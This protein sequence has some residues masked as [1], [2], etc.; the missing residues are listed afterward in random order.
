M[1]NAA[2]GDI[3]LSEGSYKVEGKNAEGT[4]YQGDVEITK[5]G[6][7]YHLTWFMRLARMA[8]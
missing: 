1:A 8:T 6:Q 2:P 7:G 4:D 5:Q 3:G